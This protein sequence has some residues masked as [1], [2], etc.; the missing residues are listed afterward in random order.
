[1]N[2]TGKNGL[3]AQIWIHPP[4]GDGDEQIFA[5]NGKRT[6]ASTSTAIAEIEGDNGR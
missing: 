1:L 2:H 5:V 6:A 4:Q 3:F